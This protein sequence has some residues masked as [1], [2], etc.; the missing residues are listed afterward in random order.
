MTGCRHYAT[1]PLTLRRRR[2]DTLLEAGELSLRL[3]HCRRITPPH[4]HYITTA[5]Y[6][7]HFITM[8]AAADI[9]AD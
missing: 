8:N 7:R 9:A 6:L 4:T 3:S 1:L 2:A 5:Y